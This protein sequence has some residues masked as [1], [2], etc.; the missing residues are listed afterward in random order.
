M[1]LATREIDKMKRRWD[2]GMMGWGNG[3]TKK[4]KGR[5]EVMTN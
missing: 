3:G 2:G 5:G 4:K 1:S